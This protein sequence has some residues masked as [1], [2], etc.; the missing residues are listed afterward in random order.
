MTENEKAKAKEI[1]RKRDLAEKG[2]LE[3]PEGEDAD[4]V[5]RDQSKHL[6]RRAEQGAIAALTIKRSG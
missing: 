3:S 4:D 1:L 6:Q 2:L 5:L